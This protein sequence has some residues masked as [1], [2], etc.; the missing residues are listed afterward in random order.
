MRWHSTAS[1]VIELEN[2]L[3]VSYIG[4]DDFLKNKQSTGR[5]RDLLDVKQI[6]K[7]IKQESKSDQQ[8]KRKR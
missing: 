4:L 7:L 1:R 3:A 6:D 5:K 2:E 8:T